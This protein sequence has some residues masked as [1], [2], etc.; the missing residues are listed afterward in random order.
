VPAANVFPLPVGVTGDLWLVALVAAFAGATAS[1]AGFG[2]G[3][4]LTPLLALRLGT[5]VAVAAVA[6]PHA[7]AT[8][9]RAWRLRE[10]V[11]WPLFRHFGVWSAAGGLAGALLFTRLGGPALTR[12]LGALLVLTAVSTLSGWAARVRLPAWAAWGL[13]LLS[14]FF[15]GVV[16]NQGGLRAGALLGLGLTPAAFVATSTLSGVVVDVV[17]TPL[18]VARAGGAVLAA[19]PAVLAATVGAIVGTLVGERALLGLSPERFRQVVAA[20]VGAL[21]VWLLARA[22]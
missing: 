12:V 14:G 6:I 10:A 4:L 9:L 11:D 13:G 8:L 19:W 1:V 7:A 3:S 2:I 22:A 16:G 18:Y 21:G 15:G 17:R 20:L 5:P